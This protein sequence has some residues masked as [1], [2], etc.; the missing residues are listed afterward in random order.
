[1]SFFHRSPLHHAVRTLVLTAVL[2]VIFAVGFSFFLPLHYGSTVRVFVTQTSATGLDPYTAVKTSERVAQ[3]LSE[4]LHTTTFF[5]GTMSSAMGFDLNYFPNDDLERRKL[6]EN[7]VK[8]K[9]EPNTGIMAITAFHPLRE[10]AHILANAIGQQLVEVSPTYFGTGVSVKV[11]DAPL[12]S[13]WFAKPNFLVN[14]LLGAFIGLLF[15]AGWLLV[16]AGRHIW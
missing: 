3:S 11:I 15:G 1:M 10:Q 14:G 2:G 12:D 8:A 13:R 4:L 6:W 9:I 16:K 7:S 5:T